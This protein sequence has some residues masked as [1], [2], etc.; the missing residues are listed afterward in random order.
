[1]HAVRQDDARRIRLAREPDEILQLHGERGGEER[2]VD[3]LA[4]P[5][6]P[7]VDERREDAGREEE[8]RGEVGHRDP[9]GTNRDR[10]PARGMRGQEA[11]SR[12][13]DEVVGRR[14]R[15]R[16]RGPER[17]DAADD[18]RRVRRVDIVPPEPETSRALRREVVHDDVGGREEPGARRE[19]LAGLQ[20]DDD[21]ALPAVQRD[22][23]AADTRCRRQ[24]VPVAVAGRR[25]D[26]HDLGAEVG[27]EHAAER[28][29]D[30][31]RV[32]DDAHTLQR[33]RH[34]SASPRRAMTTCRISAEPPEIVEPTDAR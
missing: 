26:L 21:G 10:V 11:G 7:R 18:E 34:R 29:C 30:V 4:R 8:A 23:V 14:A 22:E 1:M 25:L 20:V 17:R 13:G 6:L 15:E 28:P 12:L 32:L 31:L 9:A 24:H 27:E 5:G 2:D 33:Q 16:P 3:E 19:P